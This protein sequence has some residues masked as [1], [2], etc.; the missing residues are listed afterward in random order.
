MGF[1]ADIPH[2]YCKMKAEYAYDLKEHKG[3]FFNAWVFAVDSVEGS[4]VGFDVLTDFG[5]MFARLPISALCHKEN[6]PDIPL[7]YLELWNNFSYSVEAIEY[8]A[9]KHLRC[10]T[11]LKNKI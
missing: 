6:A 1:C 9:I 7:D 4:A 10:A 8:S 5:A 2:F 11:L 3:E